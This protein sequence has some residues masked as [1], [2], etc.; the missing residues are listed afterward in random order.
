M[1]EYVV[2]KLSKKY[3]KKK[4]L[5][6]LMWIKTKKCGYD[7]VDFEKLLKEFYKNMR[8]SKTT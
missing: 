6:K 7:I 3:G 4:N 5:I 8:V 1:E 2:K